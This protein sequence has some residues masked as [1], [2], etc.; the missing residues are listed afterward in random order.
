M[1]RFPKIFVFVFFL[2][3]NHLSFG[4]DFN[5]EPDYDSSEYYKIIETKLSKNLN[6]NFICRYIVLPSFEQEYLMSLEKYNKGK[7]KLYYRKCSENYWFSKSKKNVSI[8]KDNLKI[9]SVLANL[10]DSVYSKSL[11]NM[12]VSKELIRSKD[13][14]VY[15]FYQN[16]K[17]QITRG[18]TSN[19]TWSHNE[20]TRI[21]QFVKLNENLIL[22][23]N[24]LYNLEKL[25]T[26][27]RYFI[28]Y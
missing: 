25:K 3:I 9:D 16:N 10:I 18:K 2:I 27:L 4:D 14:V 17:S 7:Y 28:E 19:A 26:E 5:L 24:G 6:Q 22:Y 15:H 12:E 13:G 8:I 1:K 20:N 21:Q 11:K 23:I